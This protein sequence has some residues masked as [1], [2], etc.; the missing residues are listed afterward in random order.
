MKNNYEL[1]KQLKNAGFDQMSGLGKGDLLINP[2]K[3]DGNNWIAYSPT[4]SELIEACED[5]VEFHLKWRVGYWY[6]VVQRGDMPDNDWQKGETPEEA[7]SK[8]WLELNKKHD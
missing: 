1:A 2:N 8:L 6:A 7:V 4:L 3:M 5:F